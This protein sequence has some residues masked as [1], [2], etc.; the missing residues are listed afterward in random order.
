MIT[1]YGIPR[2]RSL[3]VSW[4]LEELQLDWHYKF[5]D[6]S[7][8]GN[9][10]PEFLA[11]SPE[12]KVPALQDDELHLNESAAI[13]LYL[14][15]KYGQGKWLPASGSADSARHHQ[16]VCFIISE[17]EQALWSIGKHKFALPQ[18]QRISQMLAT[19]QWEFNKAATTAA[20]R[21]P[22]STYLF[23]ES[24]QVADILLCHTLNW[25]VKFEQVLPANLEAYRQAVS[26]RPAMQQ[27]LAKEQQQ[28]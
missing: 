5:I 15:E 8:G 22:L 27:A 21:L 19:A 17:L 9:R 10:A 7:Q 24:P 3:R 18:E 20:E 26:S 4:L 13:C 25:A 12:G 23:G 28:A 11:I 6:F 16:W 14:A 1:L 2:S